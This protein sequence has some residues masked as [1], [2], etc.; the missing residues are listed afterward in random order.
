MR[1]HKE[2]ESMC[3]PMVQMPETFAERLMKKQGWKEGKT[4][5]QQ[6]H[7]NQKTTSMK[8]VSGYFH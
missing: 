7:I 2:N 1:D 8:G 4:K 3:D 5:M 6:K